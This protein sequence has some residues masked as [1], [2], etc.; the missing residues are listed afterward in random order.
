MLGMLVTHSCSPGK[1]T[2][3]D[4][5]AQPSRRDSSRPGSLRARR[6]GPCLSDDVLDLPTVVFY[7]LV[8][9]GEMVIVWFSQ[10]LCERFKRGILM[11][12]R[13]SGGECGKLRS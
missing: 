6:K 9:R 8:F 3:A 11:G 1:L 4:L 12:M 10:L 13:F 5:L 2:N 7:F